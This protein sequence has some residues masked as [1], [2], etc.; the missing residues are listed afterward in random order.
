MPFSVSPSV[1][2]IEKDLS[3]IIPSVAT[4]VGAFVGRF[5]WGPTNEIV[6]IGS[7]KELYEVFGP[8]SPDE[9]GTDWFCAANFLGY[10]DRLRVVRVDEGYSGGGGQ[11]GN[12]DTVTGS[13]TGATAAFVNSGA[14]SARLEAKF[15]GNKGNALVWHSWLHGQ[16]EPIL[17]NGESV[18]SYA[19]TSTQ[20]VFDSFNNNVLTAGIPGSTLD[21]CHIAIVDR[22]GYYGAS[23]DVLERWEG[24]SRWRGAVNSQGESLYYKDVI[25]SNS[26]YITIEDTTNRSIWHEGTTGDPTWTS[27]TTSVLEFGLTGHN[28]VGGACGALEGPFSGIRGQTFTDSGATRQNR[29][30]YWL[31]RGASPGNGT[32]S[33]HSPRFSFIQ[34][35]GG[36]KSGVTWPYEQDSTTS[37]ATNAI[38]NPNIYNI[39][40]AWTEHFSDSDTVDVDVL[41]SGAAGKLI[42]RH[43][44]DLAERRKDCV[45]FLSPPASPAGTEYNSVDGDTTWGG[46]SGPSDILTYRN[47]TLNASTSY[48]VMDSGWKYMY[49][50]YN[51]SYRWVPL[52]PDVAGLV[53]RTE[54]TTD[55]WFSPAGFNRGQIQGVIKLSINPN[56][57]QR[58]EL[59]SV[60]INPVVSFPGKGVVLFGDKTL[61]RRPSALDRINVRRLM[62]HL[63]KAISTAAKFNLFEFNDDFTR[64]AF[65][66]TVNPFLRRVQSQRGLTDF[67]VVCDETNNTSQVVDNNEFVADIFIKPARSINYIQLNFTVLRSNA[68][69]EEL[70]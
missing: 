48:A 43:L 61:Q 33:G 70:I 36:V 39:K 16:P 40:N 59:Y 52:N 55:P 1:T 20:G 67:R 23:G 18:F 4:T 66:N 17:V 13:Y 62:I 27:S 47:E 15:A 35:A 64:R 29:S 30:H 3:S 25:N 24:L 50:S 69:F 68:V 57:V 5:D 8:P 58:D 38:A 44:V 2:V 54:Q 10:G 42:S 9:R 53:V 41:I 12:A 37:N 46:Y 22:L 21:E 32:I 45:A 11:A 34:F 49:D 26:N 60:G 65:T 19:P 63:E 31:M 7:E 28:V 56:K 6:T 51:D 14:T